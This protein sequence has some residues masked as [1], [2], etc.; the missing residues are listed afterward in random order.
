MNRSSKSSSRHTTELLLNCRNRIRG[1]IRNMID[2]L[3]FPTNFSSTASIAMDLYKKLV[4]IIKHFYHQLN[5]LLRLHFL[6]GLARDVRSTTLSSDHVSMQANKLLQ[7]YMARDK[8]KRAI[9]I[10]LAF[11]RANKILT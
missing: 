8:A 7:A 6:Q 9:K 10:H 4:E 2:I 5:T 3:L 1:K 11:H